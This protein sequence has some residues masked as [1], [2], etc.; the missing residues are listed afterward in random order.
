MIQQVM[1]DRRYGDFAC[2]IVPLRDAVVI[3]V[4]HGRDDVRGLQNFA[5]AAFL[6]EGVHAGDNRLKGSEP[7][8]Q[9]GV[10]IILEGRGTAGGVSSELLI[11]SSAVWAC[12]HCNL[13]P[14]KVSDIQGN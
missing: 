3:L 11:E 1:A 7:A 10:H 5:V 13:Q 9:L 12:F 14:A 8:V 4:I 6:V 2:N